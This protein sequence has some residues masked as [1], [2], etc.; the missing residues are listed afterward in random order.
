VAGTWGEPVITKL[1]RQA[2]EAAP[3]P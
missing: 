2:R 3:T 1:K